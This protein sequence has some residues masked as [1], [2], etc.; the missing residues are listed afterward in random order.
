MVMIHNHVAPS[1][2]ALERLMIA[3]IPEGGNWTSIPTGLSARVDQ[4]KR[5]SAERGIVHTTYYGRLAWDRPAYTISTFMTRMG[6]GCFLHPGQRRLITAREAARLQTFPDSFVFGGSSRAVAQQIGNA[7]PPLLGAIIGRALPGETVVDLF[8]GAGGMSFGLSLAGKS[9]LLGVESDAAAAS[10]FRANHPGAGVWHARLGG[11]E[12]IEELQQ[13]VDELG[14]CDILVGGPPCQSFS[15][16]GLREADGRSNLVFTFADAVKR[17]KPDNF[18]MENVLGLRSFQRGSVLTRLLR[19]FAEAGYD[20]RLWDVKAEAYGVPQRR[21]RLF[22][23][24][25]L[26]RSMNAPPPILVKRFAEPFTTVRDAIEDLPALSE[27]EGTSPMTTELGPAGSTLQGWLRGQ[28]DLD[29]LFGDLAR[30]ADTG[31]DELTLALA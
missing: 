16:A 25:S 17:I 30:R 2:S 1:F 20:V 19:M 15:T 13:R 22:L 23:V 5:R 4:I 8:S 21:R 6:N 31:R 14:G 11:A 24:G 3:N 18:V 7:V 28:A 12:S 27:G 29:E 26:V 9:V 10:T